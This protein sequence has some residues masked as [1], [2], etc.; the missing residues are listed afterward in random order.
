[1]LCSHSLRAHFDLTFGFNS[2]ALSTSLSMSLRLQLQ[3][4][5]QMHF[6]VTFEFTSILLSNS[7]R[8]HFDVTLAFTSTVWRKHQVLL[9]CNRLRFWDRRFVKMLGSGTSHKCLLYCTVLYCTELYCT[10]LYDVLYC[11]SNVIQ[12]NL[13]VAFS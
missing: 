7:L 8:V 12:C 6:D 2:I 13:L 10:C 11:M 1:M 9:Y 3:I 4:H 5:F